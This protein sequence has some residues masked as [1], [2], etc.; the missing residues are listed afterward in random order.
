MALTVTEFC[1]RTVSHTPR[2]P[3]Q[4]LDLPGDVDTHRCCGKS[5]MGDALVGF[6]VRQ[7]ARA[8]SKALLQ[9]LKVG[10][11]I[12]IQGFTGACRLILDRI[13]SDLLMTSDHLR[14]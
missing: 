9:N 12:G 5:L 3:G 7:H 8:E 6:G 10:D 1:V 14:R 13:V 11:V 2:N 4:T